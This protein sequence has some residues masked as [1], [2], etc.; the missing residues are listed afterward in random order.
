M[1]QRWAYVGELGPDGA[2]DWGGTHTG[3][4][5]NSGR[6]KDLDGRAFWTVLRLAE[7]KQF[8]GRQTDWGAWAVKVNGPELRRVLEASYGVACMEKPWP[9]V[10]DYLALAEE[11]GDARY[12]AL[13]AA[14]L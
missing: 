6:L 4:V 1:T 7:E 14:E 10:D 8:E 12:V 13:V 11:L 9:P 3:S 2:L 5:P